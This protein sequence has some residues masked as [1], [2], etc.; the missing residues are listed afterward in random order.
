MFY[1]KELEFFIKALGNL[2]INSNIIA[3]N[4]LPEN[5][6]FGIRQLLNVDNDYK[7]FFSQ[8][9][10]A[11][12]NTVTIATDMFL[13]NYIFIPLPETE[14]DSILILGPYTKALITKNT[15]NEKAFENS[16]PAYI[17]VQLEK[18]YSAIPYIPNDDIIMS[19]VR[20]LC[21]LMFSGI[22]N[23][24]ISN[25][26]ASESESIIYSPKNANHHKEA[27]PWLSVQFL[28]RRYAVENELIN[29]VSKGLTNK[30]EMIFSNIKPENAL[31]SR[32]T[33]S[34][35]NTKN[36]MII[37]NTLLRK[38]AEQGKVH[39]YHI[40]IVSSDLAL[41]IEAM[42]SVSECENLLK[43]MVKKY[44]RLV[45][46]HSQKSY[47]LLIQKVTTQI[48]SD[49]SSDL[50]LNN[51]ASM[52]QINP[53]YLS[54]LFKK[55]TGATLTEYVNKKRIDRAKELLLSTNLQVQNIAQRCGILDVNYFTKTFKKY[56][57]MTP[58]TYREVNGK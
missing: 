49:I 8:Y 37:L 15:I 51:L 43:Y 17:S 4:A 16:L 19:L 34:L 3:D 38:A 29:A 18:F 14:N 31:E 24:S 57:D 50:S 2:K 21:E 35:R 13:C 23:F 40:D 20:S 1:K 10:R 46:K 5:I 25:V 27:D 42:Q 54:S 36:Y 32:L 9:L 48:E 55:E 12:K 47:S 41:K 52:F 11:A 45:N 7:R 56:T 58:K 39:P 26:L 6:D 30:A 44:C 22:E 33:D 28:E 53:S